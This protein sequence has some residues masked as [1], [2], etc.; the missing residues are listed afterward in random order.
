MTTLRTRRFVTAVAL[1]AV[2]APAAAC[3]SDSTT[4]AAPQATAA[5]DELSITSTLPDPVIDPGPASEHPSLPDASEFV[6]RIDNPHLPFIPGTTWVYEGTS[7]GEEE[8]IEVLAETRTIQGITATVVRDTVS[9]DG[10]IVEDTHDWFAQDRDGNVWY[11]G[12]AVEDLEGG[13]VVSTEGSFEAGTDGAQAGIVMPAV[14]AV[15]DAFRQELYP[16]EA[17]DM[18]EILQIDASS[19]V[20]AGSYD[21]VVVTR[22]RNPL[23]PEAVEEKHYAPGVGLIFETHSRGPEGSVELVEFTPGG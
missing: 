9:I 16:G 3:G 21:D 17:E 11:L 13:Q 1:A 22:D 18:A 15:G 19:T 6:T 4:T 10:E 20:A 5:V 7:D 12:E 14:P 8:R 2:A 23:E